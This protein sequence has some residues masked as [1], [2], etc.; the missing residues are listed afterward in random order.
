MLDL[1]HFSDEIG[2]L[3]ELRM[4]VASRA[5]HVDAFGPRRQR[6]HHFLRIQ[7]FIA[8]HV[9]DLIQDYEIIP[10]AVDLCAAKFPGLLAEADV[11]GIGLRAASAATTFSA[12]SIL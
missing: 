12:S 1:A 2:Q 5:N 6:R 8:D 7:H 11:L 9:I 4:R 10:P 3:D